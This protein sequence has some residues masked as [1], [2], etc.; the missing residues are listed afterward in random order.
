MV[1]SCSMTGKTNLTY[2]EALASE[3]A[4]RKS[5][6]DFPYELRTPVLY[7]ATKTKR[8]AFGDVAE[9]V[10]MFVKDRYFVGEIVE[11]SF[12]DNQWKESHILQ[13]IAPTE[14]QIQADTKKKM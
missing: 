1:W 2:A 8:T 5:I 10:F 9:D 12:T 11:S 6:Q 3:Q 4:A 7:L 14:E 13:V